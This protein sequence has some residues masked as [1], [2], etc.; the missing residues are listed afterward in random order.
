MYTKILR[1]KNSE[2]KGEKREKP[3]KGYLFKYTI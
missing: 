3:R 1:Q 2:R